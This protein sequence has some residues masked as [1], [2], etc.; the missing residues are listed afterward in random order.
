ML[1]TQIKLNNDRAV[2]HGQLNCSSNND[3]ID[4][5]DKS[6]MQEE[7]NSN[8]IGNNDNNVNYDNFVNFAGNE[9]SGNCT[10]V[11]YNESSASEN[12]DHHKCQEISSSTLNLFV[13]NSCTQLPLSDNDDLPLSKIPKD[14]GDFNHNGH[15]QLS[16][17]NKDYLRAIVDNS[18]HNIGTSDVEHNTYL[19]VQVKGV[20]DDQSSH[21]TKKLIQMVMLFNDK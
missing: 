14:R 8:N 3:C 13:D 19:Q 6:N 10:N 18:E 16:G 9:N 12:K 2:V 21:G 4:K 1:C 17:V 7:R 20:H 11:N 5:N 15:L